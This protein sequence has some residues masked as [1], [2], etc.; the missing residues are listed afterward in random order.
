MDV[1]RETPDLTHQRLLGVLAAAEFQVYPGAYGYREYPVA[2]FPA[3]LAAEALAFV[4]DA[5]VWSVLGPAAPDVREPLRLF[6][7][8][9]PPAADN[10]GF[11][12]WLASHLKAT[13]GTGVAVVCGYNHARGGVFDYW[14]VPVSV[15][16]EVVAEVQNLR[17]RERS[18]TA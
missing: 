11:V 4:R 18:S 14:G 10:S 16:D 12:G 8:H 15:A 6:A 3:D 7:F 2:E 13:L 9:F 1:S 5:E 17:S